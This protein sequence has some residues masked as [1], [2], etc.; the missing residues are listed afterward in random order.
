MEQTWRDLLF[1]HW[2]YPLDVV[3]AVVP[4]AL[5]ID[6]FDGRAWV[7][8]VPF[9]LENLRVRGLPSLPG[10]SSFPELNVRTYVTVNGKPGVYFFSLDAGSKL[11]VMGA[12]SL[13]HLNYLDADMTI[14]PTDRGINYVSKRTDARGAPAAFSGTYRANGEAFE[15]QRG[16]LEHFLTERYCLY[17]IGPAGPARMQIHHRPWLLQAAEAEL[18]AGSMLTSAGLPAPQG[19]ALL[20]FASVQPM[21]GWSP[22]PV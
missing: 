6:T 15:P 20:H 22:E 21:L 19:Q 17:T 7:A 1:A 5:P 18:D 13:F 12:R 8:V 9:M 3:R 4:D 14:V 11:A 2:S 16:T 10:V